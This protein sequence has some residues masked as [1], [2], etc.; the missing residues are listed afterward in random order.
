MKKIYNVLMIILLFELLCSCNSNKKS[1]DG[2]FFSL[3]EAYELG[4]IN[5]DDLSSIAYYFN[6]DKYP[7]IVPKEKNP[8]SLS[9]YEE[10]II[11][12]LYL[13]NERVNHG[14]QIEDINIRKYYGTYNGCVVINIKNK[15]IFYD[16]VFEDEHRIGDVIFYHYTTL[17]F[18]VFKTKEI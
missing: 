12:Y 2:S 13:K 11:K 3:D 4:Y 15:R 17:Q 6:S 14:Y 8:S 10:Y 16:L 7:D 5:N 1:F 9:K 18:T